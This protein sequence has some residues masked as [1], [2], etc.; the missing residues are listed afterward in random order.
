[1]K[2]VSLDDTVA[3]AICIVESKDDDVERLRAWL[4]MALGWLKGSPDKSPTC[5]L[6]ID[7]LSRELGV[8]D[9]G[10]AH[11]KTVQAAFQKT[12]VKKVRR[13]FQGG[14]GGG[15]GIPDVAAMEGWHV[16]CKD[17]KAPRMTAYHKQLAEDCPANKKPA[18]VY[19]SPLDG[20]PW[21]SVEL[22]RRMEFA[23]DQI[24]AAGGEVYF[25]E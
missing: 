15:L 2:R 12:S 18:L 14:A 5:H 22:E 4:C 13:G 24:E 3:S 1:M 17:E 6:L 25:P 19:A 16:E 11:E 10:L 7:A 23:S 8:N 9:I 20:K 21:I